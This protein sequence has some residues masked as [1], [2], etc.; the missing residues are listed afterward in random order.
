MSL[1]PKVW[2]W[3]YLLW[4]P[5]LTMV[6]FIRLWYLSVFWQYVPTL[7]LCYI[8]HWWSV[9]G[10]KTCDNFF[11]WLLWRNY[12]KGIWLHIRILFH[13]MLSLIQ[14]F[15][16][17]IN[18]LI[19]P[20]QWIPRRRLLVPSKLRNLLGLILMR[21]LLMLM[22]LILWCRHWFCRLFGL[23]K[24][25]VFKYL[26]PDNCMR[27]FHSLGGGINLWCRD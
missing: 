12:R 14:F 20:I 25:M 15:I 13:T 16:W 3:P 21:N 5:Q 18:P 6:V 1:I 17:F 9:L 7:L 26:V 4:Y 10:F 23:V 2:H 24:L 11:R 8:C 22:L 27:G 19:L